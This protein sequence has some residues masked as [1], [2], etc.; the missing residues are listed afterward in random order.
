MAAQKPVEKELILEKVKSV[1][2]YVRETRGYLHEHPELSG[3]EFETA[4]FLKAEISKLDLTITPV[5]GTGFYA[6]L[7]TKRPGKTI[8]LRA[9]IDALPIPESEVNL[10][11]RKLRLSQNPGV[12]HACGHDAF[13]E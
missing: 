8:G 12:S 9:D 1:D 7:D 11:Q 6:V 10:K 2:T 13:I 5:P 4:G 3:K